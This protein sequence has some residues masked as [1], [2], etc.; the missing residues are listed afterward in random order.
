MAAESFA[1]KGIAGTTVRDMTAKMYS[2]CVYHFVASQ[3]V[4]VREILAAFTMSV[5]RSPA[6]SVATP[7]TRRARS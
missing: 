5:R 1:H 7:A 6:C 2:G 3:D 4:I